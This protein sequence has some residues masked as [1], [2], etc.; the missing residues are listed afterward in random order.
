V[1]IVDGEGRLVGIV[2]HDD[3]LDIVEEEATEDI[4]RYGAVPMAERAYF[5]V[6]A[7]IRARRRAP[8]LFFLIVVGFITGTVI[9]AQEEL[10]AEVV[11]LAAFIPLLIDTGGNIGAQSSTVVVRGLATGEISPQRAALTLGGESLVGVM[12]AA[13][14]GLLTF[15]LGI[16]LSGGNLQVGIVVGST[17]AAIATVAALVGGGLPFLFRLVR[18]DP[19]VASAPLVTTVMDIFGVVAYFLIANA[20][21]QL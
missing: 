21:L 9:A 11:I 13:M 7:F 18:V 5:N 15:G 14:L 12:L 6:N 2:T 20:L 8:W 1:P 16:V 19:A 3:I 4:Y 17:L 10:L